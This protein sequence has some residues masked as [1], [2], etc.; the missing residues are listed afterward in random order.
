MT[1]SSA[2]TATYRAVVLHEKVHQFL[3]PKLYLLRE[4]R[5]QNRVSSYAHSSLWRAIEEALAETVAQVGV[6]GFNQLLV[7]IKFPVDKGYVCSRSV[8]TMLFDLFRRWFGC[9]QRKPPTRLSADDAVAIART[10]AAGEPLCDQL[11]MTLVQERPGGTVWI[12][13]SAGVG[14]SLEVTIDDASGRVLEIK[15]GGLR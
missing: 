12:V 6:K 4:F 15:H 11:A 13:G 1:I 8:T 9:A 14:Y 10:A 3:A 5:V 7:G 2:G